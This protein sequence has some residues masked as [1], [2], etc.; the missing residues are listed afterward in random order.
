MS[1]DHD[2]RRFHALKTWLSSGLS[3]ALFPSKA[4]VSNVFR[5]QKA[6]LFAGKLTSRYRTALASICDAPHGH[7]DDLKGVLVSR[8]KGSH[9]WILCKRDLAAFSTSQRCGKHFSSALG[10]RKRDEK[11]KS[12]RKDHCRCTLT[13]ARAYLAD[14]ASEVAHG[15]EIYEELFWKPDTQTDDGSRPGDM[16]IIPPSSTALSARCIV[17]RA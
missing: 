10:K 11:I 12:Q 14:E 5:R 17:L 7:T 2:P 6:A 3:D 9:H 1:F 16:L 4:I 15:K 13:K 8:I